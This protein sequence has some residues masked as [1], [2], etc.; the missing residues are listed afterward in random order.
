MSDLWQ[1]SLFGFSCGA[2]I[3]SFVLRH[4]EMVA[5]TDVLAYKHAGGPVG[6]AELWILSGA[7]TVPPAR[8]RLDVD[9]TIIL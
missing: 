4:H 5:G 7:H 9:H 6:R 8:R 2:N 3:P 1:P